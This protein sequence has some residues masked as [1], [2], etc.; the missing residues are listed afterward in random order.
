MLEILF[1]LQNIYLSCI[2]CDST[3]IPGSVPATDLFERV[4]QGGG[5]AGVAERLLP[6]LHR[7]EG[8]AEQEAA[9]AARPARHKLSHPAFQQ[10][11]G[12]S[13]RYRQQLRSV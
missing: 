5:Q 1:E 8:V 13:L 7:V 10:L 6:H 2:K 9:A 11:R 4:L 12:N 3:F